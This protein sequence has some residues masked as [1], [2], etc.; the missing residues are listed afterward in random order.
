MQTKASVI[1]VVGYRNSGKTTIICR[2]VSK[3]TEEGL[4]VRTVKHD[5]HR[6]EIDHSGKDTWKHRMAGAETVAITSREQTTVMRRI[7]TPLDELLR[8]MGDLDVVHVEGFK[9]ANY[10]KIVLVRT[11]DHV[12][13]IE[14]T[15]DI[16][17]LVSWIPLPETDVTVFHK[18]D[19]TGIY[20]RLFNFVTTG[21][22]TRV[23]I[24]KGPGNVFHTDQRGSGLV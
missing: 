8:E 24:G 20:T 18:D 7:Y 16:L 23:T 1:Q 12:P 3:L 6:F 9:F 11:Y 5:A 21:S 2:L 10:S 14:K 4:C 15:D 19:F 17:A 22:V 13:L